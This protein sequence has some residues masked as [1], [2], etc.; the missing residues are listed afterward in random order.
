MNSLQAPAVTG[1]TKRHS[2]IKPRIHKT[3]GPRRTLWRIA[4][5][6]AR[7][8]SIKHGEGFVP[9]LES[10]APES[11]SSSERVGVSSPMDFAI[12]SRLRYAESR[13]IVSRLIMYCWSSVGVPPACH[14]RP[15][16]SLI[17]PPP[18]TANMSFL[19]NRAR[20]PSLQ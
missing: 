7:G 20:V 15:K 11:C 17:P 14:P 5:P 16:P 2:G 10:E 8:L 18:S 9:P 1:D 19:K 3:S 6:E 12:G 13:F 4:Q